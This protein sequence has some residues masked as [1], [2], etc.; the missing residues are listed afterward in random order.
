MRMS[1][2][3]HESGRNLGINQIRT[4]QWLLD[5]QTGMP[6]TKA[7]SQR[8]LGLLNIFEILRFTVPS[9]ESMWA[10][11]R[12]S[13]GSSAF[14]PLNGLLVKPGKYMYGRPKEGHHELVTLFESVYQN[15]GRRG[16]YVQEN[17]REHARVRGLQRVRKQG[18]KIHQLF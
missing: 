10:R 16:P 6:Y 1:L 15:F 7:S 14:I 5:A 13:T 18:E 9:L 8:S 2:R 11:R 12:V 17:V 3:S 4:I